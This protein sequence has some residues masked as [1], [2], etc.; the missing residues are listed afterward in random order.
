MILANVVAK[1][2]LLFG[3]V[4]VTQ[5]SIALAARDQSPPIA[6]YATRVRVVALVAAGALGVSLFS[7]DPR[8]QAPLAF[9]WTLTGF[10]VAA[11]G[12]ARFAARSVGRF[13]LPE[14]ALDVG[15]GY[16]AVGGVWTFVYQADLVLLA[17]TGTKALLTANHFHFAGLGA[18]VLVG[19]LGRLRPRRSRIFSVASFGTVFAVV[20]VA[21]G[22]TLDHTVE[23]IAAWVLAACVVVVAI[24]TLG[25]ARHAE[26]PLARALLLMSGLAGLM[27]A[28][29]AAHFAWTGFARLSDAA[30]ERMV[31]WHG[32]VNAVGFVG[33]G[34]LGLYVELRRRS[35]RSSAPPSP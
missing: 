34:L 21:L 22:I 23:V 16:L 2:I 35:I 8:L 30:F 13:Q 6:R 32:L 17:F 27:P 1:A 24:T 7:A 29:L 9:G 31:L 28:A 20:L 4:V 11:L 26:S 5:L 18:A 19:A 3:A 10:A 33:C 14:L 12:L 25:E 15:L